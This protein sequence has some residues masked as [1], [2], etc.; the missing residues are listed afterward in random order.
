[1]IQTAAFQYHQILPI[2]IVIINI[3]VV[4]MFLARVSSSGGK[5]PPKIPSFPLTAKRKGEKGKERERSWGG[6]ERVIFCAAVQVICN[7]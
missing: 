3:T 4:L 1:M 2:C 7:Y 5:L 6:G